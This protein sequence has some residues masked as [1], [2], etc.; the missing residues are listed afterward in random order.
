[1]RHGQHVRR[2]SLCLTSFGL[3]A[4]RALEWQVGLGAI[5]H[6]G[7]SGRRRAGR[8]IVLACIALPFLLLLSLCGRR[9]CICPMRGKAVFDCFFRLFY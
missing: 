8:E 4:L 7:A 1:M 9:R 5:L 6:G 3:Q 2:S